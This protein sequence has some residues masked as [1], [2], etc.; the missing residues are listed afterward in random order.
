[1]VNRLTRQTEIQPPL[2]ERITGTK[3][4]RTAVPAAFKELQPVVD[5]GRMDELDSR[6][7]VR[8]ALWALA[9]E[10]GIWRPAA[11]TGPAHARTGS[12]GVRSAGP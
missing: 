2:V 4:A 12:D 8:Q 9:A 3:V 5:S 7:T 6:S 10:I 11:R 1:M